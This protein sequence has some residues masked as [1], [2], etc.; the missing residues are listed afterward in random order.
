MSAPRARAAYG[1][2]EVD[3]LLTEITALIGQDANDDLV[4]SLL[5]TALD[6]D[7]ADIDRLELKIANQSLVEMLEAWKV[8]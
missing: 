2:E 7:G 6:M 1:D 4:R 3:R 8:F 5:V